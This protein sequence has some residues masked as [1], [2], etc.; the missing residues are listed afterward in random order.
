MGPGGARGGDDQTLVL[1]AR[2]LLPLVRPYF[3]LCCLLLLLH[4]LSVVLLLVLPPSLRP[5]LP[6]SFP[7]RRLLQYC[8]L[9]LCSGG[10]MEACPRPRPRHGAAPPRQLQQHP[11]LCLVL[12]LPPAFPPPLLYPH[13]AQPTRAIPL[14]L[15]ASLPHLPLFPAGGA[16]GSGTWREEGREGGREKG[17]EALNPSDTKRSQKTILDTFALPFCVVSLV[18]PSSLPPSLPPSLP[19]FSFPPSIAPSLC[20]PSPLP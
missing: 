3:L 1:H 17:R 18:L 8:P 10:R 13:P 12:V 6:P 7:R 19:S 20:P 9:S 5:A 16:A 2:L 14:P 11:D 4:L 15:L